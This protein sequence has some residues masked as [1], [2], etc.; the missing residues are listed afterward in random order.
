MLK[1]KRAT[2]PELADHSDG[3]LSLT[4]YE[5]DIVSNK[6][7]LAVA[8]DQRTQSG[9]FQA[10]LIRMDED[11]WVDRYEPIH[12]KSTSHVLTEFTGSMRDYYYPVFQSTPDCTLPKSTNPKTKDGTSSPPTPKICGSL[13]AKRQWN[14]V[15]TSAASLMKT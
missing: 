12:A 1:R 3:T 6:S 2:T 7:H 9:E 4:A 14:T 13:E 11:I 10:G 8:L 5:A 15:T